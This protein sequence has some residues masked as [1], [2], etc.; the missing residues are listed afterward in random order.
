M[1]ALRQAGVA[2]GWGFNFQQ[3][4]FLG[5]A[6]LAIAGFGLVM[7]DKI[8]LPV[9]Q[10][11][12]NLSQGLSKGQSGLVGDFLSGA[13][14]TLLATPCSAPFVGTAIA[15]ALTA[16]PHVMMLVFLAMGIGLASP[17]LLIAAIPKLAHLLR[18]PGRGSAA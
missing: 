6:A 10:F 4:V 1:L 8:M 12:Q 15:F 14:A 13:L 9:P 7:M 18:V 3:P 11:A 2:I 5:I 16:E 17:W